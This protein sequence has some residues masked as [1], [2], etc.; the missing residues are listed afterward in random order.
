VEY[1]KEGKG[2]VRYALAALKNVGEA[3]MQALVATR[4]AGG[5]SKA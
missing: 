3:A 2:A 1:D 4:E 5:G